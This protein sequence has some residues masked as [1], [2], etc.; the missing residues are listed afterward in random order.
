MMIGWL[1]DKYV[2]HLERKADKKFNGIPVLFVT[3]KPYEPIPNIYYSFHPSITVDKPLDDNLRE[4]ADLLR[5]RY[6]EGE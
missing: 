5:D 4:L 1:L 6:K 2:A 3:Y